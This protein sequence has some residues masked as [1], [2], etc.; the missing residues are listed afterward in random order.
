MCIWCTV[1]YAQCY[2]CNVLYC[3]SCGESVLKVD[4]DIS[5][6]ELYNSM[7]E[8][9]EHYTIH[10]KECKGGEDEQYGEDECLKCSDT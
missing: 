2:K 5:E 4:T 9:D 3:C 7:N 1:K 10:L 8:Y 6:T